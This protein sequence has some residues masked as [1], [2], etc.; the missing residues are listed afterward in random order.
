MWWAARFLLPP[1]SDEPHC[2]LVGP[3]R[4]GFLFS[5]GV[6]KQ[7]GPICRELSGSL[8]WHSRGSPGLISPGQQVDG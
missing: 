7:R 8:N 4:Q 2:S 6:G 3:L 1:D 5:K